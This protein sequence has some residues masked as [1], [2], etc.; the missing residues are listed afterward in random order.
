MSKS[1]ECAALLRGA[2]SSGIVGNN[3]PRVKIAVAFFI[4]VLPMLAD[5][6]QDG[7]VGIYVEAGDTTFRDGDAATY[8]AGAGLLL[9][10]A[11]T[12]NF[13]QGAQSLYWDLFISN[14]SARDAAGGRTNFAQIGAILNWRYRFSGGTSPWFAELGLGATVMDRT[15]HT[16]DRQFTTN[17]QFTE[18]VGMGLSLGDH[19]QHEMGLRL[20]HFSNAGI[21][22]PNPGETFLRTRYT[23]RF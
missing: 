21:E 11:P 9:P 15:Y 1:E 19:G 18:L 12:P 7:A 17:F 5:A 23:Y 6:F 13:L 3:M 4:G 14:W 20:Q 10:W 16:P 8:S 2:K 22:K